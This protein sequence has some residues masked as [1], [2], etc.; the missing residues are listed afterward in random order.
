MST[1]FSRYHNSVN[2]NTDRIATFSDKQSTPHVESI[3]FNLHARKFQKYILISEYFCTCWARCKVTSMLSNKNCGTYNSANVCVMLL[4]SKMVNEKVWA[5]DC[6][7]NIYT[8][9]YPV[10]MYNF[11]FWTPIHQIQYG[12]TFDSF[13]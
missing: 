3:E 5:I 4:L 8:F 2:C 6:P 13:H 10:R 7:M 9:L 11:T 1:Y 12:E